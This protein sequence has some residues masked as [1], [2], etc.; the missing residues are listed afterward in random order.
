MSERTLGEVV[1]AAAGLSVEQ[2]VAVLAAQLPGEQ[3]ITERVTK[4]DGEGRVV[5]STVTTRTVPVAGNVEALARAF[6]IP[7]LVDAVDAPEVRA[8]IAALRQGLIDLL[9]EVLGF[10]EPAGAVGDPEAA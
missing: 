4:F 6:G 9:A 10:W 3:V 7:G 2:V 5:E 8:G 1:A